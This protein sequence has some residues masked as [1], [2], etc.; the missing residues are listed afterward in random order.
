MPEVDVVGQFQYYTLRIQ[1]SQS[2]SKTNNVDIT[3]N[4][5]TNLAPAPISEAVKTLADQTVNKAF[6]FFIRKSF[7]ADA[8]GDT[9][10][11]SCTSP[12][13]WLTKTAYGSDFY[14]QGQTPASNTY[15]DQ[16]Y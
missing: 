16:T 2:D 12:Y 13:S 10:S 5:E 6:N 11:I 3:I 8:N 4:H 14:F 9:F 7:F 1:L 15:G